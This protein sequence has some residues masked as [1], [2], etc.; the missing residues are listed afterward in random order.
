[1]PR[2]LRFR[3]LQTQ[4]ST[5]LDLR[6]PRR[7]NSWARVPR[8]AV[9]PCQTTAMHSSRASGAPGSAR[10]SRSSA[11]F[12]SARPRVSPRASVWSSCPAQPTARMEC[13]R[14]SRRQCAGRVAS[15]STDPYLTMVSTDWALGLTREDR[16]PFSA[17]LT[18]A[19]WL[20][21]ICSSRRRLISSAVRWRCTVSVSRMPSRSGDAGERFGGRSCSRSGGSSAPMDCSSSW[22]LWREWF[23]VTATSSTRA[24]NRA[25]GSPRSTRRTDDPASGTSS[26]SSSS[27]S[28]VSAH[29]SQKGHRNL[30]LFRW[31]ARRSASR[32]AGR[33]SIVSTR[34]KSISS[35][36]A[37]G[38]QIP[39]SSLHSSSRSRVRYMGSKGSRAAGTPL[40]ATVST[41]S[42][43][44]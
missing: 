12:C 38:S 42:T 6:N 43:T 23:S 16:E 5:S 41:T 4:A 39:G 22:S 34:W 15:A 31:W 25:S 27:G 19:R 17:S 20:S 8:T 10:S 14:A 18:R 11:R 21:S 9:C 26:S 3:S 24:V 2:S 32:A 13:M 37:M 40:Q 7:Q 36:T 35:P 33:G 44:R 30:V 28:R 29:R 1:M